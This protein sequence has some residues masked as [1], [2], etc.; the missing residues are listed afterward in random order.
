MSNLARPK[1]IFYQAGDKA[2]LLLHGL[3]GTPFDLRRIATHLKIQGFSCY[4][5]I[6]SGHGMGAEAVLKSSPQQWWQD[7]LDALHFLS[8]QGYR[9]IAIVGHSMGGIFTLRIAEQFE[10]LLVSQQLQLKGIVTMC[11]PVQQRKPEELINRVYAYGEQYKKLQNKDDK[12]IDYE[13]SWLKTQDTSALLQISQM[14]A[15]AGYD[16]NKIDMPVY[17]VQGSLDG[18]SYKRSA[19]L[20]FGGAGTTKKYLK[21]YEHSGHLIMYDNEKE[22]L[23][24]DIARFLGSLRWE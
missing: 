9:Q 20:I 8:E 4:V 1:S 21:F 2:V 22:Q 17:V 15:H 19:R 12:Q 13:I 10:Q 16:L 7:A 6:Y 14:S 3:T 11:S 18:E 24:Q 23:Q 5:P